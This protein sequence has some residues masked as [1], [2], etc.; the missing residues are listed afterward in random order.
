MSLRDPLVA[1]RQGISPRPAQ[2][3]EADARSAAGEGL[4]RARERLPLSLA[5]SPLSRGEGIGQCPGVA[6]PRSHGGVKPF[7]ALGAQLFLI[8]DHRAGQTTG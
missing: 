8:A 3:G 5:L 2:R 6:T 7:G 4:G 1:L